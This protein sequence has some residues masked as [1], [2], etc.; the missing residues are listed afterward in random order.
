MEKFEMP[1]VQVLSLSDADIITESNL[2]P[3]EECS[4]D[5]EL[6]VEL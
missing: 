3:E 6:C 5:D 1:L 2:C 4:D